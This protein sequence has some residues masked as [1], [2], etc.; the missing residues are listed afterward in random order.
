[1]TVA[2]RIGNAYEPPPAWKRVRRPPMPVLLLLAAAVAAAAQGPGSTDAPYL[3]EERTECWECHRDWPHT[4]E[5]LRSF[6]HLFPQEVAVGGRFE[7]KVQVQNAWYH[8]LRY[9]EPVLDLSDAPSLKFFDGRDP[10]ADSVGG[11]IDVTPR[12]PESNPPN[13]LPDVDPTVGPYGGFVVVEVP[14]GATRLT[15]WLNETTDAA[16][17]PV[18]WNLFAGRST[19]GDTP[20]IVVRPGEEPVVRLEGPGAFAGLGFGNWTVEAQVDLA[21][22]DGDPAVGEVTFRVDSRVAFDAGASRTSLLGR[23]LRLDPFQSTLFVWDLEATRDPAPGERV[24]LTVNGTA[25]YAHPP[26]ANTDDD[27]GNVTKGLTLELAPAQGAGGQGAGFVLRPAS[28]VLDVPAP[29]VDLGVSLVA[30]LEAVGY[31]SAFLVLASLHTG[32][33]LGKR[34]RRHLNSLLG[35]ARRRVALHNVLSYGLILAALVHTVLFLYTNLF[36]NTFHWTLGLLWGGAALLA[37][38]GLGVTGALQ[39]PLIRCWSHATWRRTHLALACATVLLTV[40]HLL[41]DGVHF[42]FV[43]E[44]LGYRN[45]L[46]PR[47]S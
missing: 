5:P 7:L 34:S 27:W 31:A 39:V 26:T 20:D 38:L 6:Y 19:P 3:P 46:D 14:Q 21:S 42:D 43:Q 40:L 22:A 23:Q 12:P 33:V 13:I 28:G 41:L 36:D 44:W 35:T 1:M 30:V 29:A 24:G 47:T 45:P 25:F 16:D 37:M 2:G 15:L 32:G 17:P 18:T 8:E 11:R 4:P 10:V 9:L